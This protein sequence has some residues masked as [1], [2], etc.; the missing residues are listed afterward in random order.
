[1]GTIY[2]D[3]IRTYNDLFPSAMLAYPIGK[4][5]TRLSYA[6]N[7][8]RPAFSQLTS[9]LT[10]INR[11]LYES[12]NPDLRP[13]Y[14]D[15]LSLALNWKWMMAMIDYAH[16]HD[17]IISA[18][19]S[20]YG[21]PTIALLQKKNTDGFNN[22]QA[23]LHFA[24]AFGCYHPQLMLALMWQDLEVKYQGE[25]K[26]MNEP[27]KIIRYN[28]AIKLPKDVWLNADF[29]W[30]SAG[31]SENIHMGMSWQFD[32]SLYKSFFH[33]RLSFKLAC[34]DVFAS[35]RQKVTIYSDV[36][37]FYL[38]KRNDNRSLKLTIRYNFNPARS[39]YKGTGA[40][41]DVKGRL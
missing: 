4:V 10:Y 16:V 17:Y 6:M 41:N 13:T 3:T 36:R 26:V 24:P 23:M 33:D 25:T 2:S 18:Y 35:M 39:K 40:G 21:E 14:R 27:M 22:L 30:R 15:N 5:Q 7:I 34:N 19:S 29:S 9:N 37:Q 38:D 31:D 12:G 1:L 20:Y 32:L 8:N 11:Y 28:N